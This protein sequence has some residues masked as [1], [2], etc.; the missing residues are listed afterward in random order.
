[1]SDSILNRILSNDTKN[2]K[3][4]AAQTDLL[5]KI[6]DVQQDVFHLVK[7]EAKFAARDRQKNKRSAADRSPGAAV[8]RSSSTDKNNDKKTGNMFS[9][10]GKMFGGLGGLAKLLA[11]ALGLKALEKALKAF[12]WKGF[13]KGAAVKINGWLFGPKGLFTSLF[14][15]K[16]IIAKAFGKLKLVN[17]GTKL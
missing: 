9:K 14:G 4:Q 2:Q 10:L 5:G 12:T 16:G 15:K 6:L 11:G 3:E 17:L 8:R 1:M 13:L 7:D